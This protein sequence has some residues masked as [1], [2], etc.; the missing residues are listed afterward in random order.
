[1]RT[2]PTATTRPCPPGRG[3]RSRQQTSRPPIHL[4][5]ITNRSGWPQA[6]LGPCAASAPLPPTAAPILALA[7]RWS[8][9]RRRRCP[10]RCQAGPGGYPQSPGAHPNCRSSRQ[11]RLQHR[12]HLQRH[13]RHGRPRQPWAMPHP[14]SRP[15][16]TTH[17]HRRV[18]NKPTRQTIPKTVPPR[19]ARHRP[20]S[21]TWRPRLRSLVHH[22]RAPSRFGPCSQT[23]LAITT[24]QGS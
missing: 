10:P 3:P 18:S 17:H 22:H 14:H 1:M 8:L 19:S 24:I 23:C 5:Q 16:P 2:E 7:Q 21:G 4:R 6:R 9:V 15:L 11:P 20:S 12:Q 13:L